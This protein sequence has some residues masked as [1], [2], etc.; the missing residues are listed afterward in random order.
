VYRFKHGV[1]RDVVYDS[2]RLVERRRLHAAIATAIET[3]AG[4]AAA[5][6]HCESL[7]YHYAG[8][9][10]PSR[11]AKYA[12]LAGDKAAASSSLDR[13]RQHY[14]AALGELE[15][16]PGS[17]QKRARW[18]G[19]SRKWA[20]ACVFSPAPE[21]LETLARAL[22]FTEELG[23]D[24]AVAHSHYWLGW[25]HYAL[26][27]QERA[28]L[29]TEH[30]LSL[31]DHERDERL[32][33]QLLANLG[34]IHTVAGE[35]NEALRCLTRA[36]EIKRGHVK[37]TNSDGAARA[38]SVPVGFAYAL[39]CQ[40]L[41][42]GYLGNFAEARL[43]IDSALELVAGSR[44]AIEASLLGLLGMIQLW[45]G[46]YRQCIDTAT[47]MRA[48][49][50]R[51]RGPYVFAMSQTIGGYARWTLERDQKALSELRAAVDWLEQHQMRLLMSFGFSCVA[52]ALAADGQYDGARAYATLAL[53]RAE[54]L[55]RLGEI[56]ARRVLSLCAEAEGAGAERSDLLKD[57]ATLA[58]ARGSLRE[59]ALV[60]LDR[61]SL[62]LSRGDRAR[63][64]PLAAEALD[65]FQA[66]GMSWHA[67][68][69]QRLRGG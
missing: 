17:P 57:A 25:I 14:R 30:A 67:A 44:H 40:G 49:A 18:L 24:R 60:R 41:V 52:E 59:S 10:K 4:D 36:V 39:G 26:G 32:A 34:Q 47:R 6:L 7:A 62:L 50:E 22:A 54:Q 45:Q 33:A 61:A 20:A 46:A 37:K 2:V 42:H 66:M 64:A 13:A 19:I 5:A 1:T 29:H 11:A 28:T 58:L 51:V 23:D 3:K 12:E 31:I 21:Q 65:E 43:R 63:G 55:D 15:R 69:A 48:A 53:E 35:P 38:E 56:T 9:A 68:K 16:L 8:A 27:E